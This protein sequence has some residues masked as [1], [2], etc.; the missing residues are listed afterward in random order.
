MSVTKRLMGPIDINSIFFFFSLHAM[1]VNG[2][3]QM[4]GCHSSEY[5]LLS[6]AE[7]RDSHRFEK[8]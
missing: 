8:T 7:E 3:H 5:L 6:S 2:A 4:F 1:E